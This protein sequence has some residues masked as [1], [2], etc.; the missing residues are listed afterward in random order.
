MTKKIDNSSKLNCETENYQCGGKC[1]PKSNKCPS[2]RNE[3]ISAQIDQV[4]TAVKAISSRKPLRDNVAMLKSFSDGEPLD[5]EKI[6]VSYLKNNNYFENYS[7]QIESVKAENVN[8]SDA[9][10]FGLSLWCSEGFEPL[11]QVIY[12]S[13]KEFKELDEET[14]ELGTK[15]GI[16]AMSAMSK[17]EPFSERRFNE[18]AA[19][20]LDKEPDYDNKVNELHRVLDIPAENLNK[21]LKP[22]RDALKTDSVYREP[23]FF[24]TSV[25]DDYVEGGT[26]EFV[27]KPKKES[28]QGRLVDQFKDQNYEEEVLYPPFSKFKVTK[29]SKSKKMSETEIQ[30]AAAVQLSKV[31]PPKIEDEESKFIDKMTNAIHSRGAKKDSLVDELKNLSSYI[32]SLYTYGVDEKASDRP[33]MSWTLNTFNLLGYL[34]TDDIPAAEK[35]LILQLKEKL[36]KISK[37]RAKVYD[38]LRNGNESG[39]KTEIYLEEV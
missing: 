20:Q 14:K 18:L 31:E 13:D 15:G 5:L 17:L 4:A 35:K 38:D 23:T 30:K 7:S 37:E 9:E 27:I 34:T 19:Q 25:G 32:D 3:Q 10:A 1:Q 26:V 6:D 39:R 12:S 8:I 22:Y 2:E 33:I 11:N 21:F 36:D 28:S 16:L 29:V 24:G